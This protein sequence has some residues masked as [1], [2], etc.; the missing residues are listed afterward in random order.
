MAKFKLTGTLKMLIVVITVA[1]VMFF[2]SVF[3]ISLFPGIETFFTN[4]N[5]QQSS[6][7]F[8]TTV[9]MIIAV[10][11]LSTTAF[12]SRASDK[13][14]NSALDV[15][16]VKIQKDEAPIDKI[17]ESKKKSFINPGISFHYADYK[18]IK[19]FYDIT[20]K[21]AIIES[22]TS[23][24]SGEV[25]GQVKGSISSIIEGTLSGKD[26]NKLVSNLK[27]PDIS[28]T[29]MFYLYQKEVINTNLVVLGLEEVEI[30]ETELKEFDDLIGQLSLKFSL[31]IEGSLLEERRKKLREKAIRK[32]LVKLEQASNWILIEGKFRIEA[33]GDLFVLTYNHPVNSFLV[34][35]S[36]HVTITTSIVKN[37]LEEHI[38]V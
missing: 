37:S 8:V 5:N 23:E 4:S 10:F 31:V 30:E 11:S 34:D 3:L 20:F 35:R 15:I 29:E 14:L 27:F 6:L 18:Q 2:L 13:L 25:G 38:L 19:I 36:K 26:T 7:T 21:Q 24:R 9:S 16:K 12:S 1:I 33:K 32:T 28:P 22:M 17:I